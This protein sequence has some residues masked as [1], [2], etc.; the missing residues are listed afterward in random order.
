M[1]IPGREE[2][3]SPHCLHSQAGHMLPTLTCWCASL[4]S[5]PQ[6]LTLRSSPKKALTA[7]TL[8]SLRR[9]GGAAPVR[10]PGFV[11]VTASHSAA[12][13]WLPLPPPFL[14]LPKGTHLQDHTSCRP[15]Y[16]SPPISPCTNTDDDSLSPEGHH[17]QDHL[18]RPLVHDSADSTDSRHPHSM[19][20][21]CGQGQRR[22]DEV[23]G[24][25]LQPQAQGI[26]V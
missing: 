12:H 19:P 14:H 15:S 8:G 24:G 21:V 6:K 2:R 26:W 4:A 3:A 13:H 16:P 7:T 22:R 1:V 17:L 25:R 23:L 10:V 18:V 20:L 11:A 9:R 5:L